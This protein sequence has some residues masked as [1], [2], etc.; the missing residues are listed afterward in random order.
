[1][2]CLDCFWWQIWASFFVISQPMQLLLVGH[3]NLNVTDLILCIKFWNGFTLKNCTSFHYKINISETIQQ[4]MTKQINHVKRNEEFNKAKSYPVEL[5][6]YMWNAEQNFVY[7]NNS[8]QDMCC[9]NH[10]NHIHV[11][12]VLELFTVQYQ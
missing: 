3:V 2:C 12:S 9:K 10:H 5:V 6:S 7:K 1:M 8:M 4:N 11:A